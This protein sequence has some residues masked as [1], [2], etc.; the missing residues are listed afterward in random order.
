MSSLASHFFRVVAAFA[1]VLLHVA[2]LGLQ[3]WNPYWALCN[4]FDSAVRACVPL[5]FMLTGALLLRRDESLRDFFIK[6]FAR[7]GPPLLF[8]SY[9]FIAWRIYIEGAPL[10]WSPI[11]LLGGPVF[12]HLW[13]LYALIGLYLALPLLRVI[14][15]HASAQLQGYL[16]VCWFAGACLLP[17]IL[18]VIGKTTVLEISFIPQYAGYLFLGAWLTERR[19]RLSHAA[20]LYLGSCLATF[21]LMHWWSHRQGELDQLF[22]QYLAPNVALAGVGAFALLLHAGERLPQR[23]TG[24]IST[25]SDCSFGIYFIHLPVLY[26]LREGWLGFVLNWNAFHPA[27][28]IPTT[29]ITAFAISF[30][31]I[32]FARLIPGMKKVV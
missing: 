32:W 23:W 17:V 2:A 4:A 29:T 20:L 10:S 25:L 3:E 7:I 18:P 15:R 31:L 30:A 26:A 9:F 16:L 12:Y 14:Y 27:L 28:A 11:R 24:V 21:A 19:L 6:R 5:F 13:Y 22:Y 8:W 1:V